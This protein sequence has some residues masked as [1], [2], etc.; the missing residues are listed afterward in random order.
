MTGHSTK[1]A[2]AAAGISFERLT[3][4]MIRAALLRRAENP[5]QTAAIP[6]KTREVNPVLLTGNRWLLR[7]VFF[8]NALILVM[9]GSGLARAGMTSWPL[10]VSA[11]LLLLAEPAFLWLRSLEK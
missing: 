7:V 9:L 3:S 5:A 6:E 4:S 2:A 10:F 1:H 11:I 8:L